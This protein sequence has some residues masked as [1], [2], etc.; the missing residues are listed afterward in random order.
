MSL[1]CFFGLELRADGVPITP[2]MPPNTSLV[3]THCAL[4]STMPGTLTLYVQSHDQP[5]RFAL[6]TLSADR[7]IF[8]AP[9]Q[10]IFAQKVSFTLVAS[11]TTTSST[12]S[13][14]AASEKY[15]TVHLTGYFESDEEGQQIGAGFD[16][17][18]EDD[19]DEEEDMEDM[20]AAG[21]KRARSDTKKE[22][23][24]QQQQQEGKKKKKNKNKK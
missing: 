11:Q 6:C 14:N 23:Q 15:P 19:D 22:K 1:H 21:R 13:S 10:L 20:E 4:T 12:S 3:L 9:L 24:Q 8:Y 7:S 18:N 16:G 2:P 17:I 5:N